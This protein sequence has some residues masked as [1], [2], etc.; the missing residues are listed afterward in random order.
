MCN[1]FLNSNVYA[2]VKYNIFWLNLNSILCFCKIS[3]DY[4]LH[5]HVVY[6]CCVGW[7]LNCDINPVLSDKNDC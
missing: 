7:M 2:N 5:V 1:G 6:A 3:L 4:I